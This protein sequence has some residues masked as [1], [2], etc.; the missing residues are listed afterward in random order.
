VGHSTKNIKASNVVITMLCII[1]VNWPIA[2]HVYFISMLV[3]IS[4]RTY[5]RKKYGHI[6]L[7]NCKFKCVST[8]NAALLSCERRNDK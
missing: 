7:F 8:G 4:I 6:G 5:D 3:S 2:F 1:F